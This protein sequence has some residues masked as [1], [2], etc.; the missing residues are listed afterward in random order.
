MV[1]QAGGSIQARTVSWVS[2]CLPAAAAAAAAAAACH[3]VVPLL[4]LWRLN[5]L[6]PSIYTTLCARRLGAVLSSRR[7]GGLLR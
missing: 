5:N 7:A 2:R 6:Q 4:L 3:T 1:T